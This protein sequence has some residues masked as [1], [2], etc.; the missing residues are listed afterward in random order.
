MRYLLVGGGGREHAIA[1]AL[2]TSPEVEHVYVAPGNGG[3]AQGNIRI[4]NV[5]IDATDLKGLADF[6]RENAIDLTMVG[7]EA[8]LADGIVDLFQ[9]SGLRCFGPT[10]QAA[11]LES[12]KAFSKAFMQRWQIPTARGQTFESYERASAFLNDISWSPVLK[13]SGLAA[14][15]GVILP[16]SKE[17]AQLALREMMLDKR[18]GEAG[19]QIVVEE[20]LEGYEISLLALCDGNDL[21]CLPAARDHKRLLDDDKGPNTGGMGA[22]AP[23]LDPSDALHGELV[24]I[25]QKV[26]D[27]MRLDGTPYSGV[28]YGGF[29]ITDHGPK[30]LEFNCRFGD[31]ET[32]AVL[33]LLAD[34][35]LHECVVRALDGT[36]ADFTPQTQT[37]HAATV[38]LASGGYPGAYNKGL[39]I[40]GLSNVQEPGTYIFHAGTQRSGQQVLTAGGRV[41]AITAVRDN[42]TDALSVAN[43]LADEVRFE[44]RHF[45]RDIGITSTSK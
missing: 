10:K 16:E 25:L 24:S 26:M 3:T 4:S 5:A 15:K 32:Q 21:V 30:V 1:H 2:T 34:G 28:L 20:R 44:G 35:F 11:Q 18:F 6:A 40:D 12:S 38:V 42:P 45:R 33:P 23:V 17:A 22:I 19:D 7:P 41:L 39:P 9:A 36:L 31:P 8:P 37:A 43:Q 29:M 27:C 13:A 14:G